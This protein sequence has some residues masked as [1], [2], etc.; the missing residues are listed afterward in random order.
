[1]AN[2]PDID[3]ETLAELVA[4]ADELVRG[5][6]AL[7]NATPDYLLQKLFFDKSTHVQDCLLKRWKQH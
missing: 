5:A 1:L 6:V 3:V 7:N 4:S 2:D